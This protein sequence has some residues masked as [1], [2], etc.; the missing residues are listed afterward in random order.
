MSRI[1]C[2]TSLLK[3]D[4]YRLKGLPMSNR[5]CTNCDMYRVMDILHII[6]QCLYYYNDQVIMYGEIYIKCPKVKR[7]FDEDKANIPYYLIGWKVPLC[8]DEE[9]VCLWFISGKAIYRMYKKA[10]T[11]KT[12]VG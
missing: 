10:I 11:D 4:D 7:V 9:M 12:G 5:T 6:T 8:S 2:H 1:M 3:R